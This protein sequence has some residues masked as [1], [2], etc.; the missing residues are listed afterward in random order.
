MMSV[1]EMRGIADQA[2]HDITVGIECIQNGE[3]GHPLL[4]G[5]HDNFKV[6]GT[7]L[8]EVIDAGTLLETPAGLICPIGMDEHILHFQD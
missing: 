2:I 8:Q 7:F 5:E 4:G 3:H 1:D 6:F